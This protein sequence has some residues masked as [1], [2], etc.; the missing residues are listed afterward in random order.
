MLSGEWFRAQLRSYNLPE[1]GGAVMRLVRPLGF[2]LA[3]VVL[4][5]TAMAA[6]DPPSS[7][8]ASWPVV[9]GGSKAS[10]VVVLD[11]TDAAFIVSGE[12]GWRV[13][14]NPL[15]GTCFTM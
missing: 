4:L 2:L 1:R 15:A 13:D 5:G 14:V 12:P 6:D 8:S 3:S 7:G 10:A 11:N 9:R